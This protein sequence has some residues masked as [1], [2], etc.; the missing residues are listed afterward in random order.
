[1]TATDSQHALTWQVSLWQTGSSQSLSHT[2]AGVV[3][4]FVH[5]AVHI[6]EFLVQLVN[7]NRIGTVLTWSNIFN[8]SV[9]GIDTTLVD[10]YRTCFQFVSSNTVNG[11]IRVQADFQRIAVFLNEDVLNFFL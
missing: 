9:A 11:Q 2:C 5:I 4:N 8:S 10:G 3:V 7:V 1:M 6:A